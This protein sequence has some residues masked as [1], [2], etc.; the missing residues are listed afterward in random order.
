MCLKRA[1]GHGIACL[2]SIY[3][4]GT[5]TYW[6]VQQKG[7]TRT[8]YDCTY[9]YVDG[10]GVF[11]LK[12]SLGLQMVAVAAAGEQFRWHKMEATLVS[13]LAG[14]TAFGTQCVYWD[15]VVH[16]GAAFMFG[17]QIPPPAPTCRSPPALYTASTLGVIVAGSGCL[18]RLPSKHSA[19]KHPRNQ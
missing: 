11:V 4:C 10:C 3:M 5:G 8:A 14:A 1:P 6:V 2:T 18:L 16:A 13:K 12:V 17:L 19:R 15:G 7:L 9:S